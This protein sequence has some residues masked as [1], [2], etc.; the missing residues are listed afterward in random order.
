MSVEHTGESTALSPLPLMFSYK[1]EKSLCAAD[2]P[3]HDRSDPTH[4]GA[5]VPGV[6]K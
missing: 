4:G 1:S 6:Y 2:S 5:V 3:L